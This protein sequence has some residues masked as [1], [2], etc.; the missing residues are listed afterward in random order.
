MSHS[1]S[2]LLTVVYFDTA[3]EFSHGICVVFV[4]VLMPF[5]ENYS[6]CLNSTEC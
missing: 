3:M 2:E 5:I 4:S 6:K 1:A